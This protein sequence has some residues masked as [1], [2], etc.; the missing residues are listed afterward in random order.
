MLLGSTTSAVLREAP[1]PVLTV[2]RGTGKVAVK[3][4]LFPTAFSPM[5]GVEFAWASELAE[6]FGAVLYA[7]HVI[8]AHKSYGKAK[9]GF[10]G[11]LKD[12]ATRQLHSLVEKHSRNGV[13]V[14]ERVTVSPR[15]WS[16]IVDFARDEG[17]DMIVMGTN[18][19][20]GVPKFFLGS[21]AEDVIQ[22][23][24]CPVITVRT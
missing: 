13:S 8:E 17:I 7:V 16:A 4:I 19:R 2:R 6:K 24:P 3:K 15:A 11:K 9:G 5:A 23:S 12:S 21:V 18:A 20:R 14:V 10:I 1:V 22:E